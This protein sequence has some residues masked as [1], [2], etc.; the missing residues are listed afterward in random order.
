MRIKDNDSCCWK[1]TVGKEA[2][3]HLS[4]WETHSL[5]LLVLTHRGAAL[6][7]TKLPSWPKLLQNNSI[8]TKMITNENLEILSR[9]RFRNG[10]ANKF[11][12]I[13]FRICFCNGH[14]GHAQATTAGHTYE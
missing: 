4:V 13:F 11:P 2:S 5:P 12:Q 9:F 3:G 1:H 8:H 7:E 14:V 10:K 6:A